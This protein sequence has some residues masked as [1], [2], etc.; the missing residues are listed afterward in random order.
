MNEEFYINKRVDDQ[1]QWYDKKSKIY[2]RLFI[3]LRTAEI[4][5]SILIPF[6][7]GF[8][9]NATANKYI[10]GILGVTIAIIAGILSFYKFQENWLQYRTTSEKLVREKNL[11]LAKSGIYHKDDNFSFFVECVENIISKENSTW[12][13]YIKKDKTSLTGTD[14]T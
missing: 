7:V 13:E 1:I 3:S 6:L 12:Q 9:T 4:I 10:I 11:F 14:N 2:K 5:L 8:I